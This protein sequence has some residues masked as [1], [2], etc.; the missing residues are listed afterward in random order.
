MAHAFRSLS[1]LRLRRD[2]VRLRSQVATARSLLDELDR[3][4]PVSTA[5]RNED[6]LTT[7]RDQVAEELARLG[8]RLLECAATVTGVLPSP[9]VLD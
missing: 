8:C 4:V 9:S 6:A 3:I 1:E 7:L 5:R 2:L